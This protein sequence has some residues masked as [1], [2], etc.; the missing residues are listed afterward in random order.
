MRSAAHNAPPHRNNSIHSY[1]FMPQKQS[2]L[3]LCKRSVKRASK[4]KSGWEYLNFLE[5]NLT[6]KLIIKGNCASV[7]IRTRPDARSPATGARVYLRTCLRSKCLSMCTSLCLCMLV[8]VLVWA[9]KR[10]WHG[11]YITIAIQ[12]SRLPAAAAHCLIVPTSLLSAILS[13]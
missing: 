6:V 3:L 2:T 8:L 10:C 12:C 7:Y 13:Q 4:R 9:G 11:I 1:V 5:I